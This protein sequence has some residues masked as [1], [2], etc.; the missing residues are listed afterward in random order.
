MINL[1]K[2]FLILLLLFFIPLFFYGFVEYQGSKYIYILF[3]IVSFFYLIFLT[4]KNSLFLENFMGLFF[5]LCYWFSLTVKITFFDSNFKDFSD[6]IGNF[7]FKGT[8]YDKV[9]LVCTISFLAII[10]ASYIRRKF[11]FKKLEKKTK[12]FNIKNIRKEYKYLIILGLLSIIVSFFNYYFEIYQ[13]GMIGSRDHNIIT[14]NFIK[15]LVLFGITSLYAHYIYCLSSNH[16]FPKYLIVTQVFSEFL[17]NL[18]MLSRAMIFN[19]SAI[20]WG[21]FRSKDGKENL[22]FI[23]SIFLISIILFFVSLNLVSKMR[24]KNTLK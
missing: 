8:S 6:G 21:I 11:F 1:R 4:N 7:D 5:F 24:S 3:S 12:L 20:L 17:I 23:I 18:S 16:K 9:L 10:F 14:S 15:W 22:K 2:I 13:R 19:A